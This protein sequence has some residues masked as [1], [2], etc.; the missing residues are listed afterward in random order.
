MSVEKARKIKHWLTRFVEYAKREDIRLCKFV[1]QDL[2]HGQ[3]NQSLSNSEIN[4]LMLEFLED[5][6]FEIKSEEEL[7]EMIEEIRGS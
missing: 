5:N 6:G 4:D 2:S 1:D 3:M 7:R